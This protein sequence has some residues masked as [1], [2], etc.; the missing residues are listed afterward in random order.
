MGKHFSELSDEACNAIVD[1]T[2]GE[3][4]P[5]L[6]ESAKDEIREWAS[7]TDVK[8]DKLPGEAG[9]LGTSATWGTRRLEDAQ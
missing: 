2:L 6:S 1:A 4:V 9:Q 8:W 5:N 3:E 7:L